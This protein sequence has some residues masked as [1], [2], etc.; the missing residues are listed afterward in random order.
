MALLSSGSSFSFLQYLNLFLILL[1]VLFVHNVVV[2]NMRVMRSESFSDAYGFVEPPG[3]MKHPKRYKKQVSSKK[4]APKVSN[5]PHVKPLESQPLT[6]DEA[7]TVKSMVYPSLLP[8]ESTPSYL[9]SHQQVLEYA[10]SFTSFNRTLSFVH[11]PKTGGSTIENTFRDQ[12]W[13]KC[14]FVGAQLPSDLEGRR[15]NLCPWQPDPYPL[16]LFYFDIPDWHIPVHFF[17]VPLKGDTHSLETDHP[18]AN[19]DLFAVVRLPPLDRVV[20]QYF[21]FCAEVRRARNATLLRQYCGTSANRRKQMEQ[22]LLDRIHPLS[23]RYND[24][25]APQHR[26]FPLHPHYFLDHAHWIP[27][28]DY[29]VG[30]RQVRYV[31]HILHLDQMTEQYQALGEAYGL[32]LSWSTSNRANA[33]AHNKPVPNLS[34]NVKQYVEDYFGKDRWLMGNTGPS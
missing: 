30:P 10:S 29:I 28:F 6:D 7:E 21:W 32:P 13:G 19:A 23:T 24:T 27:Q 17:P 31:N 25:A 34:E 15:F 26:R 18:Y 33:Q 2:V 11:I 3:Q 8:S 9:Y 14:L 20:S 16:Q 5:V 4:Q 1:A 12:P 22:Y